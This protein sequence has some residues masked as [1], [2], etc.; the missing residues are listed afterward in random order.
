MKTLLAL[1]LLLTPA[2]AHDHEH[3]ENDEW[4][5]SLTNQINGSCCDGSDALSINDPD[6]NTNDDP[7][8]VEDWPYKVRL[9]G[10]WI[11]VFKNNVVKQ[12]NKLGIA[13]VWPYKQTDDQGSPVGP[14]IIRCFL[15]GSGA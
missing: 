11:L 7:K 14:W 6:W 8:T 5:R 12:T 15:P 3:P 4:L 10:Q 1:F 13:R 2:L 9:D